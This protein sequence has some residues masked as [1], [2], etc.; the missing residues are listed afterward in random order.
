[1]GKKL[2][3]SFTA[4]QRVANAVQRGCGL[5]FGHGVSPI[6]LVPVWD[7]YMSAIEDTSR[8]LFALADSFLGCEI[9]KEKPRRSG[10][11]LV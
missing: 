6:R 11:M 9:R 4:W 5:I 10:A 2:F 1:M 3:P 7:D 8:G